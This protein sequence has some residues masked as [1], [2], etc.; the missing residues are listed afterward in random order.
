MK[1][2]HKTLALLALLLPAV[3]AQALEYDQF[4]PAQST[5]G[6]VFRQMNV[7][8]SGSF[9]RFSGEVS[10]DPARPARAKARLQ[11]DLAS[12]DAG[13]D[14]AND[15]VV[16]KPWFNTATF[17][18]A[19][20]VASAVRPVGHDRYEVDGKMTVKGRTVAVKAPA[21]FRQ[22]GAL[23]VFEGTVEIRRADFSIG[24]G[25]W[26]AFDTVA[27]EVQIRFKLV[28]SAAGKK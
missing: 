8:V 12:V 16:D 21:A 19:T 5:V 9:K 10:F 25:S 17:P 24:E 18:T 13:S 6:F 4:Q 15:A 26:A 23:G 1:I 28:A 14:E 27:N 2:A 3:P 11:I 7:P 20:F 22:E